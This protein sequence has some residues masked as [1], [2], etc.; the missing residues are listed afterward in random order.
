MNWANL[1]CNEMDR[2]LKKSEGYTSRMLG[3]HR[4]PRCDT[5]LD[6]AHVLAVR[7]GWL[8]EGEEPIS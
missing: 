2:R 3:E 5:L 1:G 8:L 4:H 7:P 6:I